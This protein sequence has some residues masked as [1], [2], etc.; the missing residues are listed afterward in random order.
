MFLHIF[1]KLD[2]CLRA[3]ALVSYFN[4]SLNIKLQKWGHLIF[5]NNSNYTWVGIEKNWFDQPE[6]KRRR[7]D[8]DAVSHWTV[9][10]LSTLWKP[11]TS[12]KWLP[13]WRLNW[14]GFHIQGFVLTVNP[15]SCWTTFKWFS[16]RF[17]HNNVN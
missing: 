14:A 17:L 9:D 15:Y 11:D 7:K 6:D 4:L 2:H 8:P 13:P 3:L 10:V 1:N 12:E 5:I 16:V